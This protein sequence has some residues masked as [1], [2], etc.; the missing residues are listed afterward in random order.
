MDLNT[1]L[2]ASC[3][4]FVASMT[5]GLIGF[6]S[7]IIAAPLL[8]IIDPTLVPIPITILGFFITLL[9]LYREGTSFSFNGTQYA[10]WGRIPG[11]IIGVYLL[12]AAPSS[13]LGIAI[14]LIVFIAVVLS[15]FNFSVAVNKV[16]LFIAGML[17]GLFGQVA[18]IGGPPMAIILAGKEPKEFRS[19]LSFYFLFSTILSLIIFF[20]SGLLTVEHFLVSLYL[21]PSVILG[22]L[23]SN[24]LLHKINKELIKKLTLALCFVCATLLMVTSLTH[25]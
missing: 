19:T 12:I 5:Q 15:V 22:N 25:L 11:G 10:L 23:C 9:M 17:S 8:Y 20:F 2:L 13:I 7:A 16:N 21:L 1:L 6:G 18:A 14:S 4:L 24:L 3:V